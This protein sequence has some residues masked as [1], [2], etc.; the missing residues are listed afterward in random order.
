MA[1]I[2]TLR[3]PINVSSMVEDP[4]P[5]SNNI[6]FQNDAY[7]K[8]TIAPQYDLGIQYTTNGTIGTSQVYGRSNPNQANGDGLGGILM[9]N[10][11]VTHVRH[12]I[13]NSN[14]DYRNNIDW[15]PFASM[16]PARPVTPT[17]FFTDGYN[18]LILASYN[19]LDPTPASNS[20]NT[21]MATYYWS[22]LNMNS[23]QLLLNGYLTQNTLFN[24]AW[25]I[26]AYGTMSFP[27]Y[28]NPTTDRIIWITMGAFGNGSG[29]SFGFVPIAVGGASTGPA[30]SAAPGASQANVYGNRTNQFL[31][32]S[33]L[34]GF[35]INFQNAVANDFNQFFFKYNDAANTNIL[36]GQILTAPPVPGTGL[37]GS[38]TLSTATNVST[39]G[40]F[41]FTGTN[42]SPVSTFSG[43][44]TVT[45]TSIIVGQIST[46]T[47]GIGASIFSSGTFATPIL[48]TGTTITSFGLG[49]QNG[50]NR[51]SSFGGL[52]PKYA[53]KTF[54]DPTT[55]TTL[56]FFVPYVD[57]L[58]NFNPLY[59]QW[60][61][62]ND[63]FDRQFDTVVTYTTG[64]SQ[65]TYW[66]PDTVSG[67]SID[68]A[69]GM[70][71]AWYNEVFVS[72]STRYLIFM[73]L[74]GAGG[75]LD[76]LPQLRTFP[77]YALDPQTP[78][79]MRF[80]SSIEVPATP[81][82][83]V[84]L[85]DDK[86]ILGIITH[87]ALYIYTFSSA[88]GWVQTGNFPFQFNAVGRDNLGRVWGQDTGPG[89]G[90]LHLITL[91]VP[92]N[93]VVTT[94]QSSYYFAGSVTTANLTVN[95]FSYTGQRIATP[96]KLV[97][98][99]GSMT[100]AGSNLT[101][102]ITTSASADTIVPVTITGGGVANIIA[103][104]RL[105]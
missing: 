60:N 4:T 93:I 86:T 9:L 79:R 57:A 46:G 17:K 8:D 14:N 97:I 32:V 69:H 22:A 21:N 76:T 31:G 42:V 101:L 75:V 36:L 98:D 85:S 50:G 40:W 52:L 99:G 74:H 30:F 24:F 34:D 71:R 41:Y 105:N 87:S 82:N 39:S 83:I 28:R 72:S 5:G 90:R 63:T 70:Q 19:Y 61:T 104:A 64:T 65:S 27:V 12:R 103:S 29:S 102:N 48:A 55:S 16:D 88:N 51:G 100:F 56:G 67:S 18:T 6:F 95:A 10:G 66:A 25:Q 11:E 92:V 15:A 59:C 45:G 35:S 68:V 81:K 43:T 80:V 23:R 53:S 26:A 37:I 2:K 44:A 3:Y 13:F 84:W 94:D 49:S 77:T 62:L 89:W 54:P 7:Y 96:I 58:G 1:I 47:I 38:Y 20:Y 73:Q 91:N 78:E 33:R